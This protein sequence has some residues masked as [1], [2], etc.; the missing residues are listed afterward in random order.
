MF[1][2]R[3]SR[4]GR[5]RARRGIATSSRALEQEALA[6]IPAARRHAGT[7]VAFIRMSAPWKAAS[8]R[9]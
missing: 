4:R 1:T 7:L 3:S 2:S 8:E 6:H 5:G 9:N